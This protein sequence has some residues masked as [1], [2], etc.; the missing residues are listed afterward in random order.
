MLDD[1]DARARRRAAET[2]QKV[3]VAGKGK[4]DAAIK[5]A[6]AT[7]KV[8]IAEV[9]ESKDI[10]RRSAAAIAPTQIRR[11]ELTAERAASEAIVAQREVETAALTIDAKEAQLELASIQL[12]HH[13]IEASRDGVIVELYRR[14]GEWVNPGDPIMRIV[15]MDM[16]R[17]QGFVNAQAFTPDQLIDREAVVTVQLPQGRTERFV[18]KISF[19][20]PLV[21]S[22]EF[23]VWC[24]VANRRHKDHWILRPGNFV[25]MTIR[26]DSAS[27]KLAA[28]P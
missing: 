24:D 21:E 5:A 15:Y 16:V 22:G 23:R 2:E 17:V 19:A 1:E 27:G 11:Q 18:G 26:L 14:V 25:E 3:A 4:A 10:N 20:S 7:T 12:K 9:E 13:Q 28:S 6:E 8:A